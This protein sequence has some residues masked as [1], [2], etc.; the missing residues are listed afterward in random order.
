[1]TAVKW[2]AEQLKEYDFADIKDNENYII[3]IPA[4]VLAEKEEQAKQIEKEREFQ[5]FKAGQDSMEEGGK[6]FDQLYQFGDTNEMIDQFGDTNKMFKRCPYFLFQQKLKQCNGGQSE[7]LLDFLAYIDT[8]DLIK[9][10]AM[11]H[12]DLVNEFRQ[13]NFHKYVK[14]FDM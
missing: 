2:L 14:C 7:L 9:Y 5:F 12:K 11:S 10:D 8:I 1:M 6:S 3:K 13:L 4:W